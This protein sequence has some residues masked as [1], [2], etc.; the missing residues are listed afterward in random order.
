MVARR[1]AR[2]SEFRKA[3]AAIKTLQTAAPLN[4]A[5]VSYGRQR[6]IGGELLGEEGAEQNWHGPVLLD[7]DVKITQSLEVGGTLTVTAD[8]TFEDVDITETLDVTAEATFESS[9]EIKDTL[10]V[11]ATTRLRGDTTVEA[12]MTVTPPGKIIAGNLQIQPS[13]GGGGAVIMSTSGELNLIGGPAGVTLAENASVLFSL[14]VG[15]NLI[16]TGSQVR[17]ANLPT[18]SVPGAPAGLLA[19]NSSGYLRVTS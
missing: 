2:E 14:N 3:Q 15:E 19:V 12:D 16:V 10:D 6:F 9:V 8:S 7:G 18:M 13:F 17:M 5:S 4:S 1:N 11:T